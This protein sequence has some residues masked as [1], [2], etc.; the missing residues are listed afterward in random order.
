MEDN[1]LRAHGLDAKKLA[2]MDQKDREKIMKEIKDDIV[3]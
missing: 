3:Q 2:A 1:W